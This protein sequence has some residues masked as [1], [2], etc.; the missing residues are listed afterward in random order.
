MQFIGRNLFLGTE[1]K[2][3]KSQIMEISEDVKKLWKY[4]RMLKNYGN[5]RGC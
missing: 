2:G 1:T 4:P 3:R 5:I